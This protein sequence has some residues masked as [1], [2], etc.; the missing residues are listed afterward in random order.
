MSEKHIQRIIHVAAKKKNIKKIK[1][2]IVIIICKK[3]YYIGKRRG[4][5][6]EADVLTSTA[7]TPP[8]TIGSLGGR[9]T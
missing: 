7:C 1:I 3:H 5:G 6:Q 2:K 4:G 8:T 9:T